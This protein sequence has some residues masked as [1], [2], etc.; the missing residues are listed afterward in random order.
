MKAMQSSTIKVCATT[1]IW[2]LLRCHAKNEDQWY[3]TI[4]SLALHISVQAI[5]FEEGP[6]ALVEAMQKVVEAMPKMVYIP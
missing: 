5:E 2:N 1:L 4:N 6:I 3:K